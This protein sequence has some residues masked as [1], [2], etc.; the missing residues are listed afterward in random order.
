MNQLR[1]FFAIDLPER[2]RE[3]LL[4]LARKD[5]KDIWRWT[6]KENLHLTLV[7]I[8]H[9]DEAQLPKVIEAGQD[10]CQKNPSFTL[11][12]RG[13]AYGP[14]SSSR[15]VWLNME[16]NE[17]LTKLK[18]DLEEALLEREVDF[19]REYREFHPHITLARLKLSCA[20]PSHQ[21]HKDYTE[22]FLVEEMV[23]MASNL[24]R[25]GAEYTAIQKFSFQ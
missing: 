12:S 24:K 9:L 18:N 8:G 16:K 5:E 10:A 13:I 11:K 2:I 25:S 6:P 15:M 19:S 23:L 20:K 22:D 7:F 21:I 1:L 3:E 17:A 14:E 4:I